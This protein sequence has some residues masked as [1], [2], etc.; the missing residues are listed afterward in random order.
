MKGPVDLPEAYR[1]MAADEYREVEAHAWAEATI[2]DVADEA[3]PSRGELAYRL[4]GSGRR[5]SADRDAVAGLMEE[6]ASEDAQIE[7]SRKARRI[8]LMRV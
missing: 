2:P 4:L 1:E 8:M 6:R 7:A 3:A 5:F